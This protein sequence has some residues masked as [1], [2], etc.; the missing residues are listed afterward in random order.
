MG[1]YGDPKLFGSVPRATL[2]GRDY[3]YVRPVVF[4]VLAQ[5]PESGGDHWRSR[6]ARTG[7]LLDRLTHHVH[8]LEMNLE[9]N[10]ESY[11]LK[12]SKKKKDPGRN[13]QPQAPGNLGV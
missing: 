13:S 4:A 5:V 6:A 1:R 11:Q 9:V 10:G 8:I 7:A 3:H 2:R 12:N